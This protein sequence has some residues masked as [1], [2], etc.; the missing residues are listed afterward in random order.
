MRTVF[1]AGALALALLL[2]HSGAFAQEKSYNLSGLSWADMLL[3]GKGLGKLPRDETDE[4]HGGLWSRIQQQL[5]AQGAAADKARADA[6]KAVVDKAVDEAVAKA[7]TEQAAAI[8]KAVTDALAAKAKA[9]AD[10]LAAKAK[11]SPEQPAGDQK[12]EDDK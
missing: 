3:V 8:D 11:E 2:G 4:E 1:A 9:D 7:R 12:S 10:A 6:Q 5:F